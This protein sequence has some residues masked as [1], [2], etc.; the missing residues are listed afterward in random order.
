MN[1]GELEKGAV[2]IKDKLF[3]RKLAKKWSGRTVQ[4]PG[5]GGAENQ[6]GVTKLFGNL[7]QVE[8]PEPERDRDEMRKLRL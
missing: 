8:L 4:G 1:F 5:C 2:F 7:A 3:W 6:R